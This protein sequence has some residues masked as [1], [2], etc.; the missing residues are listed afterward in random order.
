MYR[1]A[2]IFVVETVVEIADADQLVASFCI[3]FRD[4]IASSDLEGTDTVIDFEEGNLGTIATS[5]RIGREQAATLR[6]FY[7]RAGA[8]QEKAIRQNRDVARA[9]Q[10]AMRR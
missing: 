6:H 7:E 2:D 9:N 1:Y 10:L 8:A 3:N 4:F 5:L